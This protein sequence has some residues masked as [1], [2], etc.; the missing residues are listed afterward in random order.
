MRHHNAPPPHGTD[1][2]T[3]LAAPSIL[4][5]G[6]DPALIETKIIDHHPGVAVPP[7]GAWGRGVGNGGRLPR[8]LRTRTGG[9][10]QWNGQ[11]VV[12]TG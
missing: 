1:S 8:E 7:G 11:C 10:G 6:L 2:V 3:P 9:M 5:M 12:L 4:L